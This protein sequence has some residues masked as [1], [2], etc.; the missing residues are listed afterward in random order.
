MEI[1]KMKKQLSIRHLLVV[2]LSVWLLLSG[3]IATAC[4]RE[5]PA[6][7]KIGVV[8]TILPQAEFVEKVG[9]DKVEVT[10]MVP[11]GASPHTYEPTPSQMAALAKAKM[12]AKVGSGIDFELSW[13]NNLIAQNE[14]MLVVD[15]SEG[16]KL[17]PMT[18]G[19]ED[20]N[21]PAGSPDPHIWLSPP[22]AI[23]MVRNIA[24][25]LIKIDPDNR[26]YY[27]RNRDAYIQ[28]LTQ[29][30]SD[31]REGLSA[32]TNRVFMVFHP[33]FGYFASEY[34]LTML[35]IEDKGKEPTPAGMEYLIEQAKEHNIKVVF[36][37]PQFNQQSADVIAKE[38]G[39]RVI[40]IDPLAKDYID[41][42]RSLMTVMVQA[43]E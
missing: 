39:G 28:Q 4:S 36:A 38:I 21:E 6:V 18:V 2:A 30:D 20:E 25:G 12:Y 35:A 31:I 19:D 5:E 8:V 1:T 27:E 7:G 41:N 24:D 17:Q 34:N 32:V 22:N 29:L 33:A 23:I 40:L 26:A 16:I 11:P 43:M 3:M 15:C 13:M 14:N 37:E 42:L 10:V 9:G